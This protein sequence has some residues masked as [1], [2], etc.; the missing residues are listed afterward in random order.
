[1]P[2]GFRFG[3]FLSLTVLFALLRLATFI[4]SRLFVKSKAKKVPFRFRWK[5]LLSVPFSKY[6]DIIASRLASMYSLKDPTQPPLKGEGLASSGDRFSPFKGEQEG[7]FIM[8]ALYE[9]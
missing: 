1:M 5:D 9:L 2:K 3:F 8:N 4:A 7:V 6:I